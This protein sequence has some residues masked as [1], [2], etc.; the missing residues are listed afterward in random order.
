M[1]RALII[2]VMFSVLS[3]V[4][5]C[6]FVI[7][8]NLMVVFLSIVNRGKWLGSLAKFFVLC[9]CSLFWP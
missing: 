6:N 2:F 3:S 4:K 5:F 9:F 8:F 7:F 1:Q